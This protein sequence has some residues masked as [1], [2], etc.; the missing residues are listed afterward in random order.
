[1]MITNNFEF[2]EYP[3]KVNTNGKKS[4]C[5]SSTQ[6]LATNYRIEISQKREIGCLKIKGKSLG[7]TNG[8]VQAHCV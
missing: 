2:T 7:N 4:A 5:F 6:M 3:D 8:L 1:M